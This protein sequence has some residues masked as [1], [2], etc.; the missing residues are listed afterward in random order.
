MT[1][2]RRRQAASVEE[3]LQEPYLDAEEQEEVVRRLA[4]QQAK[5][6]RQWTTV[7]AMLAV[8]LGAGCFYLAWHQ[9]RDPWGLRHHAYFSGSVN[10]GIVALAETCSGISLLI[11]AGALHTA[12]TSVSKSSRHH[13][14]LL[15]S[16]TISAI[17]AGLFWV[18]LGSKATLF[19]DESVYHSVRYAWLPFGP[20]AYMLLVHYLLH[21]FGG[22]AHEVMSL[23]SSMYNFHTA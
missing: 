13:R 22:T 2:M 23:K 1:E 8:A 6:S 18:Y 9:L 3:L 16:C 10:S 21:S 4:Q 11:T 7:F 5:Q 14:L 20:I 19:Q 12:D 15:T 17:I